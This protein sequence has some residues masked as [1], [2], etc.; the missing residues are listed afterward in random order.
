MK[1]EILSLAK[2]EQVQN[3]SNVEQ[4]CRTIEYLRLKGASGTL[5]LKQSRLDPAAHEQVQMTFE[6]L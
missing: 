5:L 4:N 2:H 3:S 6:H 1:G